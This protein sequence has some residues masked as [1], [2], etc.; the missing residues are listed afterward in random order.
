MSTSY[1]GFGIGG[2]G[3][4]RF[5]SESTFTGKN[6]YATP[7]WQ[8]AQDRYARGEGLKST[9]RLIEGEALVS[10]TSA[11]NYARGERVFHEK[12]GYGEITAVEGN[13]L[14]VDFEKAGE[15]RV[16][17]SFISRT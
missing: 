8:R 1:G 9:P 7:G 13:K 11:S 2:Y 14:T 3:Q 12:F 4:S 17:D 5:D 10:S 15:K 6:T 16:I